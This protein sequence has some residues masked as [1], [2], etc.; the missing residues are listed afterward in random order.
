MGV[1]MRVLKKQGRE[2]R[3]ASFTFKEPAYASPCL[4]ISFTPDNICNL[5]TFKGLLRCC[6][7]QMGVNMRLLKNQ[8]MAVEGCIFEEPAR[9][10]AAYSRALH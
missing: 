1:I 4:S 3:V 5:H 2:L 8:A 6:R 9:H 10:K 7:L